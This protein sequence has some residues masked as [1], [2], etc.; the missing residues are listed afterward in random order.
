MKSIIKVIAKVAARVLIVIGVLVAITLLSWVSW[1]VMP[2]N[3]TKD[4]WLWNLPPFPLAI[5][6]WMVGIA[7][8]IPVV[9]FGFTVVVIIAA[10]SSRF[11]KTS[12]L[13]KTR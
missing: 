1:Q 10:V 2:A 12:S 13:N 3:P 6:V 11:K 8:L 9:F 7:F 5:A 4:Q